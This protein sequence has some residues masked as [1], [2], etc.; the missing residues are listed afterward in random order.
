VVAV[1]SK[2]AEDHLRHVDALSSSGP[3]RRARSGR[4]GRCSRRRPE[5]RHWHVGD[6]AVRFPTGPM[7]AA[8]AGHFEWTVAEMEVGL[9][10]S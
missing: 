9:R 3:P 2:V 10:G 5:M 1:S 7:W 4:R 8:G 6:R